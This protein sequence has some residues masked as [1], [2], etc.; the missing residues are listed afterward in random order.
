MRKSLVALT[1]MMF[2]AIKPPPK[3]RA[4]KRNI[5]KNGGKQWQK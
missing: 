2:E 5:Y 3:P 1:V 4:N